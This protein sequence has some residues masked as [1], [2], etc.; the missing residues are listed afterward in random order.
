MVDD[1]ELARILGSGRI[2]EIG[3]K[4]DDFIN[5]DITIQ[6]KI[7]INYLKPEQIDRFNDEVGVDPDIR[8]DPVVF[9][10][11]NMMFTI[12]ENRPTNS[13]I[14]T[15]NILQILNALEKTSFD[16]LRSAW[17][18]YEFENIPNILLVLQGLNLLLEKYVP[19]DY[20]KLKDS[21]R[22]KMEKEDFNF[23]TSFKIWVF[24]EVPPM[25]YNGCLMLLE[26]AKRWGNFTKE[27]QN[28]LDSY[29]K[30]INNYNF[31][32]LKVE[33]NKNYCAFKEAFMKSGVLKIEEN[34]IETVLSVGLLFKVLNI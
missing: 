5:K 11:F 31:N 17:N 28:L 8:S 12:L 1:D 34:M 18:N 33:V 25:I 30:M 29:L 2:I 7:E 15:N 32:E 24:N 27:D 6:P 23:S 20:S 22:K 3:K 21:L 10:S 19:Q 4:N 26:R 14:H 9:L 13:A 16:E